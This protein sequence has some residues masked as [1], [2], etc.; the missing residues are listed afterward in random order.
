MIYI[1]LKDTLLEN[2]DKYQVKLKNTANLLHVLIPYPL[3][4]LLEN[5]DG[6]L[7]SLA[8][9]G[10]NQ[11]DK[12]KLV[13]RHHHTSSW[14]ATKTLTDNELDFLNDFSL[15]NVFNA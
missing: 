9:K 15:K 11:A 12:S 2:R 10:I 5:D 7:I 3:I 8:D 14:L 4:L 1:T 6:L 13:L